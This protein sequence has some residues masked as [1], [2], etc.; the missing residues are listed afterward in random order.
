MLFADMVA[1]NGRIHTLDQGDR[2]VAGL[3]ALGGRIVGLGPRADLDHAVG[4]S[5]RVID[6]E[7]RT[8]VPGIVDSHCH[9]DTYAIRMTKW[10]DLGPDLIGSRDQLLSTIAEATRDSPAGAWFVGYRFN[11]RGSGGYPTLP[12]LDVAGH[13]RPVFILRT[14]AHLGL[15]NSA[16]FAACDIGPDTPDPAFGRFD[17][18]PG[19]GELTGLVRE[20]AAHV[21]LDRIHATDTEDEIA[22]GME[23]VFDR[24]LALGITSLYNSLTPSRAIR[25]YQAMKR[26][27]RMRVRM[28]IIASGREHGLLEALIAAGLRTGF[29]DDELR[30]I[31]VEWCPDCS[32]S[33]RTAAYYEP[34][35]GKP[36][37][38]EPAGNRGML[39]YEG[40]DLK[41][42][43]VAAHKAG[44]L[45]CIEGVGD[46]GID[47]ALDA[48]EAALEARPVADHR[49]RVEHCCYVTPPILERLKRLGA[50]DS[51]A[52]G[53]MYDLGDAYVANRGEAAMRHM[54]PHRSLID[55]GIPAPGHSDAAVCRL[56]P[57]TAMWAMVNR[58]SGQGAD[59][60]S[61]E[62]V[63]AREALDAYTRLGAWS[64]FE[65][66]VK[67]TLEIGKVADFLVLDRD[68]FGIDP[69]DIRHVRPLMTFVGGELR[70][71]V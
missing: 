65:E 8:V 44:L 6:L 26:A 55:A 18:A 22:R 3:A 4:P 61:R 9:P 53:F 69:D 13:G 38:G 1:V 19:S 63:T 35:V 52:T 25:A 24:A 67:G 56:D 62:A 51:S 42:R 37:L 33:G 64:G 43:A 14:D 31:G 68:L 50:V 32:T 40:E 20:T 59:L 49:M 45:V 48:I 41:R 54:W 27:G 17:R 58:K 23:L 60:D 46:R 16:A 34:Y 21:F 11:E 57:W 10:R 15:A 7:G 66:R 5:T 12:E 70:H 71:E 29:G 2:V 36:V 30:L 39:L 28:G 47:F